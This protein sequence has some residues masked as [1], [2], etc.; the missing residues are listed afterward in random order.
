MKIFSWLVFTGGSFFLFTAH[1][2]NER[3]VGAI[4]FGTGLLSLVI[5]RSAERI[6]DDIIDFIK[7]E[8]GRRL[9]KVHEPDPYDQYL[10][11]KERNASL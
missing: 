3:I 7:W 6:P 8:L 5:Q 10:E 9:P 4:L 11:E 1:A 2:S